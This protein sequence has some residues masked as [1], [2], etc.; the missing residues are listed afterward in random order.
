MTKGEE[1]IDVSIK[2]SPMPGAAP[3]A[4]GA[5]EIRRIVGKDSG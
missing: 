5:A 2:G 4:K 1:V 3:A